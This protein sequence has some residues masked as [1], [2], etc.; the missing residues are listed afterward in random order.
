M[1]PAECYL[2][3]WSFW[4]GHFLIIKVNVIRSYHFYL[5]FD[6]WMEIINFCVWLEILISKFLRQY[7][8]SKK[9]AFPSFCRWFYFYFQELRTCKNYL[10]L[11]NVYLFCLYFHSI[12]VSLFSFQV[13]WRNRTLTSI[14]FLKLWICNN[15]FMN[16]NNSF[17]F[18]L[19][20][21][22][23]A[24]INKNISLINH[25]SIKRLFSETVFS[26]FYSLY[27]TTI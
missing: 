10:F 15:N 2:S 8:P 18:C 19:Y 21:Q 12:D 16:C 9:Y 17:N 13:K 3:E 4:Q 22:N 7:F 11:Q 20:V 14:S 27:K 1:L 25:F 5:L 24:K 23:W 26:I 6:H